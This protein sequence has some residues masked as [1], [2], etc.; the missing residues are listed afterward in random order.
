MLLQR[1]RTANKRDSHSPR[2]VAA[3]PVVFFNRREPLRKQH[4]TKKLARTRPASH[5]VQKIL[6]PC[7]TLDQL[8]HLKQRP[9]R[10]Q[11]TASGTRSLRRQR[12]L[13]P[14]RA[15]AEAGAGAWGKW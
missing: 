2:G 8:R 4:P 10:A 7:R 1:L 12:G 15:E 13:V 3:G 6:H 9:P 5:P 14:G 11:S